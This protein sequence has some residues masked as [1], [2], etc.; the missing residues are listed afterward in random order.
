MTKA[1]QVV[2]QVKVKAPK[3]NG[4]FVSMLADIVQRDDGWFEVRDYT[5][6]KARVSHSIN[7][8]KVTTRH[9]DGEHI[10]GKGMSQAYENINEAK[11]RFIEYL[12]EQRAKG[13]QISQVRSFKILN[14]SGY[15]PDSYDKELNKRNKAV[16]STRYLDP[17]DPRNGQV[18]G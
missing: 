1:I 4:G 6:S 17:N 2:A 8:G 12:E 3:R 11:A 5:T 7:Y 14:F 16:R 18:A 9:H 10:T 15:Q 13:C